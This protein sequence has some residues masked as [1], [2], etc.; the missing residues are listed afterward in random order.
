MARCLR[1]GDAAALER[2]MAGLD[3]EQ[4][5]ADNPKPTEAIPAD[6]AARYVRE[7]PET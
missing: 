3:R 7:L 4:P 5:A 1:D 6:V 2:T